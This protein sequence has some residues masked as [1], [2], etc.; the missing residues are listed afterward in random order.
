MIPMQEI[1]L[2]QSKVTPGQGKLEMVNYPEPK[3]LEFTP[4]KIND[5]LEIDV[6][7]GKPVDLGT[8]NKVQVISKTAVSAGQALNISE[9]KPQ[10][11]NITVK[12]DHSD[13]S[14]DNSNIA[15]L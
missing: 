2:K 10:R 3:K 12:E 11:L 1:D 13:Q 14:N 15:N 9:K 5:R 4:I 8:T 6:P 7:E